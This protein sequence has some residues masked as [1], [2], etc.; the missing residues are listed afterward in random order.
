M[1]E[2]RPWNLLRTRA[3]RDF[4]IFVARTL[5][6]T[7]PRTGTEYVRTILN[8]PDWVNVVAVTTDQRVILV[9][10]FRFGTWSN[11]LEIP[12]GIVDPHET[13]PAMTARRELEE[14]TGFVPGTLELL[15]V[16][17]P[18]PAIQTNRLHSY[19]ARD[20]RKVHDGH[21]EGSEDLE[22]VLA[23]KSELPGLVRSGQISHSLVL[24]ALLYDSL[25]PKAV[26]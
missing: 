5:D 3:E 14:E 13:D 1:P 22:L 17:R 26:S 20:C 8:C 21:P 12:G 24:A 25:G 9:R 2:P 18:N 19:L 23:P 11:T 10:Q 6:V 16:S 7:D 15:G 4:R